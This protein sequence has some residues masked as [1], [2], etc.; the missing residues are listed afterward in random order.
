MTSRTAR[1]VFCAVAAVWLALPGARADIYKYVDDQGRVYLT[2]RP[3]HAGYKRIV[4]TRKGWREARINFRDMEKNRKRFAP[5]IARVAREAELPE[6]LIHAVIVAESAYDPEAVSHAGAVGLM[7]LMPDT[8]RR[9][10]VR[11]RRDPAANVDG[12]T[13]YLKDLLEMFDNSLP[14]A[15]AGYNAGENAVEQYGRQIPPY[16]ETQDYV[17]KVLKLYQDLRKTY[18]DKPAPEVASAAAAAG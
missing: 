8:A 12:G 2:D 7:Q 6:A 13:R 15:L 9:Y 10:G 11:D 5:T 4:K 14:L 3:P 16:R 18:N 1:I 17:R